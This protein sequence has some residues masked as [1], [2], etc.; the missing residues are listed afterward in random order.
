[1]RSPGSAS[2][3]PGSSSP[4][5]APTRRIP[6]PGTPP[7]GPVPDP[8]LPAVR[9]IRQ[10][11]PHRQGQPVPARR[12][13]PGRDGRG[14]HRYPAGR[15][16][17]PH[18]PQ[19]RQAEGHRRGLPGHLRDRLDPHL[20][21]RR[22]VRRA[23]TRTTTAPAAP[24]ARPGTRSARSSASTPARRSSSPPSTPA[25][26]PAQPPEAR[27]LT[28]TAAS[29]ATVRSVTPLTVMPA[30]PAQ[31]SQ[32]SCPGWLVAALHEGLVSG[33]QTGDGDR[34]FSF[35]VRIRG[36]PGGSAPHEASSWA[37][38]WG[39]MSTDGAGSQCASVANAQA[40]WP[41]PR[42]RMAVGSRLS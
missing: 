19:A 24:P 20:R 35:V 15:A 1:M 14:Q 42:P 8:P 33:Q 22:P 11:R 31:P 39:L 21:P 30:G 40:R 4:S 28:V 37:P 17:P 32:P 2:A 29:L 3:T 12:A 34:Q 18:R 5:S 7:P 36:R 16:V 26:K 23:G 9:G 6:H 38:R 25:P 41:Y 27:K 10:A 13:R